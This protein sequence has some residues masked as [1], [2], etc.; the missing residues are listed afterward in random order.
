MMRLFKIYPILLTCVASP[1]SFII[2]FCYPNV[3]LERNL[4]QLALLHS[5]VVGL[6][7]LDSAQ[8][9]PRLSLLQPADSHLRYGH[10]PSAVHLL[11]QPDRGRTTHL[12][13]PVFHQPHRGRPAS[14]VGARGPAVSSG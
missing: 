5:A 4:P 12:P 2:W 10:H 14:L 7:S 1:W 11:L 13:A 8:L 6:H 9:S 3:G